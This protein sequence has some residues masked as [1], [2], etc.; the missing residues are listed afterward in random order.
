MTSPDYWE[1][2]VACK[3]WV[4]YNEFFLIRV[5]LLWLKWNINGFLNSLSQPLWL[6]KLPP[7]AKTFSVANKEVDIPEKKNDF[8]KFSKI[9][10]RF[11]TVP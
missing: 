5:D 2:E 3:G 10:F 7:P 9:E 8:P 6:A 1:W 11:G 4:V